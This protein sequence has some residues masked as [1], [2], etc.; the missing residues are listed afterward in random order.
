[1]TNLEEAAERITALLLVGSLPYSFRHLQESGYHHIMP[2]TDD[3][4]W[5]PG[6]LTMEKNSGL[7]NYVTRIEPITTCPFTISARLSRDHLG[8]QANGSYAMHRIVSEESPSPRNLR[9]LDFRMILS[10]WLLF[11]LPP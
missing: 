7:R 1:M 3:K 9:P 11:C 4:A 8:Q 2:S 5:C 10:P 6:Q